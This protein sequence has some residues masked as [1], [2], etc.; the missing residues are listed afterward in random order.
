MAKIAIIND[1]HFGFKNDS[2]VFREYFNSFYK[3]VF[4]PYIDQHKITDIVSAGDLVDR[5]RYVNFETLKNL[6][7]SY[8]EEFKKRK[9]VVHT[10]L[11]NHD[12]YYKSTNSVNSVTELFSLYDCIKI[13]NNPKDIIVDNLKLGL[14]PWITLDNEQEIRD[15]IKAT[16]CDVLV[17]H[18][19]IKGFE[20]IR[21][22]LSEEGID[23]SIFEKFK[24]VLS[25]HFHQKNDDGHIFYLGTQYDMT[26]ADIDE[27]KGFHVLD[28]E[29]LH[30][31]FIKNPEKLYH[32]IIYNDNPPSD[33]SVY[34]NKYVRV[35]V[36]QKKD[37]KKYDKFIEDLYNTNPHEISILDE[38]VLEDG[39][40]KPIDVTEDTLSIIFKHIEENSDIK[41]TFKMKQ[42][43]HEIYHESYGIEE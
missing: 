36:K 13:Y 41:N 42:I 18:F 30:L 19:E 25:G 38:V 21:G 39:S 16:D 27:I 31:D 35:I 6:R 14:V 26:F 5:R 9:I 33:L 24:I 28:T 37:S 34:S 8:I 22:V 43:M 20:I 40:S 10:I 3:N 23:K 17:G 29:T 2:P 11:G 32:K 4:F 15:Y 12:V 7:E 1:Q